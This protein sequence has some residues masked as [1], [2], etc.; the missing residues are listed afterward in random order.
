MTGI[1]TFDIVFGTIVLILVVRCAL[2]G[3]VTEFMSM[4]AWVFGA[5]AAV[6]FHRAG[7]DFVRAN[8]KSLSAGFLPEVV[9]FAALFVFVFLLVT[10]LGK[11]LK[12][13][14]EGVKL[15]AVDRML[16]VVLGLVEGLLIVS[17]V[18]LA[19]SVLKLSSY[20]EGSLFAEY[21]M[22][23]VS[24]AGRSAAEAASSVGLN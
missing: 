3:F 21:L 15:G 14:I 8:V 7:A 5:L 19:M 2:R 22:P 9:A 4:A 20:L 6:L 24:E 16:G 13:V 23:L 18:L 1:A 12:D 11:V 10:I 17:V